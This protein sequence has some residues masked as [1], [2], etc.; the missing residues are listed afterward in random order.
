MTESSTDTA[1]SS[2]RVEQPGRSAFEP[3]SL[4]ASTGPTGRVARR[5]RQ[6][7]Q[8]R[9]RKL[10]LGAAALV[11]LGAVLGYLAVRGDD[12]GSAA[13]AAPAT[14]G[15]VAAAPVVLAQQD[16]AG[17]ATSLFVLAPAAGGGGTVV[18]IPP[19]TMTEIVSL[20]LEPVATSLELGGAERLQATVENLLGVTIGATAVV[21]DEGLA[22]MLRPVGPLTVEV[23]QRV[24]EVDAGGRVTVLYGSGPATVEPEDAGR[25][26]AAKGRGTDLVRLARHQ[27]FLD[28]WFAAARA[29]AGGWTGA[30]S[31]PGSSRWRRSAPAVPTASSTGC[32][33][34]SWPRWWPTS[35]RRRPGR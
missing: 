32:G 19:G 3:I 34:T 14:P 20:G 6:R 35:S 5:R 29:S 11:V 18:L 1:A 27:R 2:G 21:D 7:R 15:A 31:A 17:R 9:N 12:G 4:P 30:R 24:E 16:S 8:R 23:P 13:P 10:G 28:A 25:F 33:T 22:R 26:L